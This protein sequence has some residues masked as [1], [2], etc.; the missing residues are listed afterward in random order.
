TRYGGIPGVPDESLHPT[1]CRHPV[2]A[3]LGTLPGRGHCRRVGLGIPDRAH[4]I[5]NLFLP[6]LPACAPRVPAAAVRAARTRGAASCGA[7][8]ILIPRLP[9]S[10][11]TLYP[12]PSAVT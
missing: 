11:T 10:G 2:R 9:G 6:D 3:A 12:P 5:C 8:R 4:R 1:P 7:G